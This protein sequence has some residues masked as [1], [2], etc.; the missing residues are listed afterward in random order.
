MTKPASY[1]R[2]RGLQ[3]WLFRRVPQLPTAVGVGPLLR[4]RSGRVFSKDPMTL[5]PLSPVA[6]CADIGDTAGHCVGG[7][8]RHR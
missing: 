2:H 4:R 3:S 8:I 1:K 7:I 6:A 5:P